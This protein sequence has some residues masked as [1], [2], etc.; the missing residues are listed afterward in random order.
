[1]IVLL[2]TLTDDKYGLFLFARIKHKI[3]LNMI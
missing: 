2:F 1:M 3:L